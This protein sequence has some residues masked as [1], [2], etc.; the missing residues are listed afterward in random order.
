MTAT[1]PVRRA[2]LDD[3]DE[4]LS[5]WVHYIRVHR[6]NPAYRNMPPDA[7][8]KRRA[9]FEGHIRGEDSD[10]FV[11]MGSDGSLEGMLSCFEEENAAYFHPPKYARIRT[12][13][14]RPEA[15]G[16]GLLKRMLDEA[17]RWARE[18]E[19]IEVRLFVSA[20]AE[21]ANQLAEEHG[22][23]AIAVIRRRPIKWDYPSD[24]GRR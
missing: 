7:L 6:V 16:R 23:E 17:Y 19:L 20:M 24:P 5:L 22:F 18:R 12:P 13:F 1:N 8:K 4:I 2:T 10:V 14:V 21:A 11:V 15:R 3:L 9:V